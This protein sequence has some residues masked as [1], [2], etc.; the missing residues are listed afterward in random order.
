M[1]CF[2]KRIFMMP[3][4]LLFSIA[5]VCV[6][7]EL[8]GDMSKIV[9]SP[10]VVVK[11]FYKNYLYA[12][13][14]QDIESSLT[15]SQRAIDKYTT[16]SLQKERE[17][18]DSGSDYFLSAQEVCSDWIKNIETNKTTFNENIAELEL[19]LGRNNSK[20]TYRVRL[21]KEQNKWLM[22]SVEFQSRKS[23]LCNNE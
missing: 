3:I 15:Q 23:E 6:A 4:M 7:S 17:L 21:K 12:F 20:S 5:G 13:N 8:D 2:K 11:E 14:D 18:N 9:S 22:D 1:R 16:K 10:E 19:D